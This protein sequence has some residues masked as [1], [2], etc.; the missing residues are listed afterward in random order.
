MKF[1]ELDN[2]MREFEQSLDQKIMRGVY[3]VARLD[4]RGFTKLTKKENDFGVPFD[5]RFRDM[6]VNTVKEL[7]NC[8]FKVVYGFTQ[9][10]EISLLFHL[11][12]DTYGRKVRKYNSI[13]AGV[14]STAFSLQLGQPGIFDC[15]MIPLPDKER[16]RDYFLWRQE[17][18][19]RNAL[20]AHCY[21]TLRKNGVSVQ[22]A[23]K[24]FEGKS[25]S[26]KK[27]FLYKQ[28]TNFKWDVPAWQKSGV[29]V[30]WTDVEKEGYN[31]I[32]KEYVM[33]T[34]RELAVEY[35]LPLKDAYGDFVEK[36]LNR[37]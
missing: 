7:M 17:D 34:R 30:F 19:Y 8:G 2:I 33:T 27:S 28:G 13:L 9:S 32:T 36:K 22:E 26:Y 6:M 35:E 29:G 37:R 16:V 11:R 15:R 21:W 20:N 4:G 23:T 25:D 1:D 10:D 3:I 31:P 18:A 14:A 12:E 24:A 5:I